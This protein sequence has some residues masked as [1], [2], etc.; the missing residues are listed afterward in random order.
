MGCREAAAQVVQL[1]A[2]VCSLEQEVRVLQRRLQLA[3]A[4]EQI[5]A[6]RSACLA[7]QLAAAKD[8]AAVAARACEDERQAG[9]ARS[10]EADESRHR[11]EQLL[12]QE[13][14]RSKLLADELQQ[15]R[16]QASQEQQQRLYDHRAAEVERQQLQSELAAVQHER[17][18]L[19]KEL[20]TYSTAHPPAE[21]AH[22]EQE[23]AQLRQQLEKEQQEKKH[24]LERRAK[25]KHLF[26]QVAA[27]YR[28][29]KNAY[30][31]LKIEKSA[32]SSA[33]AA[34]PCPGQ[35][36]AVSGRLTPDT[37]DGEHWQDSADSERE[38]VDQDL[39][40][41]GS[42][43]RRRASGGSSKEPADEQQG[44]S[45]TRAAK[46]HESAGPQALP[47][48]ASCSN[49][50]ENKFTNCAATARSGPFTGCS[51]ASAAASAATSLCC[52]DDRPPSDY[53]LQMLPQQQDAAVASALAPGTQFSRRGS[54]DSSKGGPPGAP[55]GSGGPG[56]KYQDV[57]R[58]QDERQKLK[59]TECL[60][61][62]RFYEAL[63][64]WGTVAGGEPLP[65]C[66][67]VPRGTVPAALAGPLV[68]RDELREAGSRH[69]YR[70]QPPATPDEFWNMGF[71]TT[72]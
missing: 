47:S 26:A 57:V 8:A 37:A 24:A 51:G 28:Q 40:V 44:R 36:S 67:H 5:Q 71:G 10:K 11:L 38:P 66:G 16:E 55:T 60:Q 22:L 70:Y 62:Q 31:R 13:E 17:Q 52:L 19:Q 45:H 4:R 41:C 7:E 58:K 21:L 49:L 63:Q 35:Q 50:R 68:S 23:V 56:Y 42:S 34:P 25:Y 14:Q 29:T 46:A 30:S 15:G 59:G 6:D 39:P 9:V 3:E 33:R 1:Q 65:G 61:C 12:A 20:A 43:K 64:T 27:A 53:T 48:S 72:D 32:K 2:Q 18:R 69:R 54:I